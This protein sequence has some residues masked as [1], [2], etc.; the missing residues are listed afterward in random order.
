MMTSFSPTARANQT[1]EALQ[2]LATFHDEAAQGALCWAGEPAGAEY[3][4]HL[5]TLLATL[6][7]W[8]PR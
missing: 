7:G 8:L 3:I 2:L 1:A 6:R 5:E 4:Q